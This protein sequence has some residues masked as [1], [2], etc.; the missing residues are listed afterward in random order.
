MKL[1]KH[2]AVLVSALGVLAITAKAQVLYGTLVGN[3]TDPTS[4]IVAA[5]TVNL[6]SKATGFSAETKTDTR[7]LYE[8][9]N[10]QAGS[11]DLKISA[12]GFSSFEVSG[13]AITVNNVA[14]VDA[15]LKVG[16]VTETITVGAEAVQLQTDKSD[17][18]TDLT[19]REMTQFPV[20]G[21]RNYQS[22][23]DFVPGATPAA[24]QNA[25]IDTPARA[26]TTNINGAAR[27]SNNNRI[28]GAASVMT[29]LPHHSF[30]DARHERG[31]QR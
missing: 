23:I 28:D 2:C 15:Q 7:G 27:N 4:G 6:T 9:R 8:F 18:H 10:L 20:S 14:R 1:F 12:S 30:Q 21:F 24:F 29:W 19:S 22:L 13:I 31:Q 16:Q 5:A 3:V 25:S 17:L 11:Y 26:L